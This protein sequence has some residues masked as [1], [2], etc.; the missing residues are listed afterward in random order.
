M[1][2]ETNTD[3]DTDTDTNTEVEEEIKSKYKV[4]LISN[5]KKTSFLNIFVLGVKKEEDENDKRII[6]IQYH[7]ES[8]VVPGI[9]EKDPSSFSTCD[10]KGTPIPLDPAN[11]KEDKDLLMQIE[12]TVM[13]Y[14]KVTK[15]KLEEG[16]LKIQDKESPENEQ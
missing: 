5:Q 14:N 3:T 10:M 12:K 4:D 6:Y 16:A 1:T 11:N 13:E 9:P 8:K 7:D 2:Q 15:E